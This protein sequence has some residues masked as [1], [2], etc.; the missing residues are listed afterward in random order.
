MA[1]P[2]PP[3]RLDDRADLRMRIGP[4][5]RDAIRPIRAALDTM[6]IRASSGSS[7]SVP[8]GRR[9]CPPRCAP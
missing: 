1:L 6:Q 3:L 4:G 8:G 9:D 2:F 5:L 7:I